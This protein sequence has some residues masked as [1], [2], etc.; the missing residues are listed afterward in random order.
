MGTKIIKAGLLLVFIAIVIAFVTLD[1]QQYATLDYL[2]TQQASMLNYYQQH[3]LLVLVVFALAYVLVTAFSLP[4][5]TAMTLLGGALFGFS[6]GLVVISFASSV[7]ATLAFLM[8]R[9]L[10]K[11]SLQ[12]KYGQ[13]LTKVNEGFAREGAFYLFALRLVPAVP[14]FVVNALMG[15]LP[16]KTRTFY[17]VSQLGMLPATAVYVYAGTELGKISSLSH[18]VSPSLLAALALL[19]LL[20]IAAKKALGFLRSQKT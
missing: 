18:I 20:P 17:W 15:L 13:H 9:F 14:F 11:D 10:L 3:A 5:A 4:V 6:T 16:I 12:K 7:G 8:A 1:V 19:G 2:K